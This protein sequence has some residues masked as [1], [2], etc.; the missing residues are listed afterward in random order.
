MIKHLSTGWEKAFARNLPRVLDQFRRTTASL[1]TGFHQA[2]E[3]CALEMQ[4]GI[5]GLAMLSQ[6]L[7]VYSAN[8]ADVSGTVRE[9]I[10]A[11]QREASREFIPVIRAAMLAAY[12]YCNAE[13]GSY[14]FSFKE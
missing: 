4:L 6:Q 2:I 5:P 14:F 8:L 11:T 3:R 13:R 9:K 10:N 1:L 12:N 7:K